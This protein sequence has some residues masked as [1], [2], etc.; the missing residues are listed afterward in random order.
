MKRSEE[1]I[2]AQDKLIETASSLAAFG[3]GFS[4]PV[5]AITHAVAGIRVHAQQMDLS[6]GAFQRQER[7]E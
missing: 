7:N 1:L 6:I 2:A 3:D 5:E 4:S